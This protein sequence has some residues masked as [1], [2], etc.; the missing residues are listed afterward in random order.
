MV[1]GSKRNLRGQAD[2][3]RRMLEI[4]PP[5]PSCDVI[6]N[7]TIYIAADSDFVQDAI[8]EC[9]TCVVASESDK[10][11]AAIHMIFDEVRQLYLN[12]LCIDLKLSGID[13]KT[14]PN[15]DPYRDVRLASSGEVCG[16]TGSFIEEF[17]TYLSEGSNDPSQGDR[18]VF[19]LFYGLPNASGS[20][21][22][23]CAYMGVPC[24]EVW[25]VGV[26]EMSYNGVY[27]SS[28]RLKRNLLAHEMGHNFNAQHETTIMAPSIGT[29]DSF[30]AFSV[31]QVQ[32][33]VNG[34]CSNSC[35]QFVDT[36]NQDLTTTTT[37]EATTTEATTTATTTS[38]TTSLPT[39]TAATTTTTTT[40]AST[41]TTTTMP[42]TTATT[43][44]TT[45]TEPTTTTSTAATTQAT[46]P[47]STCGGYSKRKQCV[48]DGLCYWFAGLCH[49]YVDTTTTVAPPDN[50]GPP[51][52][53][54]SITNK[55]TCR[56]TPGCSFRKK[57]CVDEIFN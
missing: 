13:I 8:A 21:T 34:A 32:L 44:T 51:A 5:S 37:T 54:S 28:M 57:A 1:P 41:T 3:Q 22:I 20:R 53:C 4:T 43:T 39:T 15:N 10:A 55:F 24:N 50:D 18:T 2:A 12:D 16:G 17:K 23:G 38:S 29:S 6:A 47:F 27:S 49:E 48:S 26:N 52:Q 56:N 35:M 46:T 19:H 45:T 14:D 40:T 30:S 36:T 9:D 31:N 33:C 7:A 25:G 11:E 42:T